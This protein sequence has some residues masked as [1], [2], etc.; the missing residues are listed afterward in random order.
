MINFR[1]AARDRLSHR[2]P[3]KTSLVA[4]NDATEEV[5]F[6]PTGEEVYNLE[7]HLVSTFRI[8]YEYSCNKDYKDRA[9]EDAL[10]NLSNQVYG[11]I[12]YRLQAILYEARVR[13][14]SYD[15]PLVNDLESLLVDLG[16]TI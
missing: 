5:R 11:E 2:V 13:S 10:R 15:D 9:R 14:N 16:N 3:T 6:L 12:S 7:V 8:P 4:I 1:V